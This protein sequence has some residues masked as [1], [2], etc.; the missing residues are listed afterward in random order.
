MKSWNEP[1]S[2]EP[3]PEK[4]A[5][6]R[7]G[8]DAALT[9]WF[10]QEEVMLVRKVWRLMRAEKPHYYVVYKAFLEG[11]HYRGFYTDLGRQLGITPNAIKKRLCM[12]TRWFSARCRQLMP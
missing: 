3:S 10:S 7:E 12:A 5:M 6:D 11:N 4:Q 8:G 9:A 1:L 2:R